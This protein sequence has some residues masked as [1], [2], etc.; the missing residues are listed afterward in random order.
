MRFFSS[1]LRNGL[2]LFFTTVFLDFSYLMSF[3]HTEKEENE[4]FSL[5]F[6]IATEESHRYQKKL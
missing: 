2:K 4:A 6:E 3:R 1:W 5:V